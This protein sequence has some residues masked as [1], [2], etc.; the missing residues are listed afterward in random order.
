MS[1]ID[2]YLRAVRDNL[3]RGQQDDIINEL[4]DNLHSRI[5]DDEAARGRPLTEDEEVSIL[6]DFGHPM[7]VAARYRG[8]ERS[9]TFGRRLIGPELFPTYLKVLAINIAITAVIGVVIVLLGSG[10][11]STTWGV[12]VPIAIQFVAVTA[13]FVVIDQRWIRD[14]EGWDPR[15]V[16]SMGPDTSSDLSD[17]D[18][19][20]R[21]IVGPF[22]PRFVRLTTSIVEFGF[23]LLALTVWLVI[24]LPAQIAGFLQPGPGW[25]EPWWPATVVFAF[26]VLI[27]LVM[28]FRPTWTRFRLVGRVIVYV[29]LTAILLWSLSIGSWVVLLD[30]ATA[31]ADQVALVELID[32]IVRVSI[33]IAIVVSAVSAALEVRWLVRL[34]RA[35]DAPATDAN[36]PDPSSRPVRR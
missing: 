3:P 4:S 14:P 19:V 6:R 28:L 36:G 34:Q 27:P 24:G 35:S 22:Y 13:I 18:A 11:V 16:S 21:A 9:V 20:A 2:R 1:L 33:A 5:E 32:G 12:L 31:T 7:V 30:P 26:S 8:D 17:L 10:L 15:T 23:G 29:A 25:V